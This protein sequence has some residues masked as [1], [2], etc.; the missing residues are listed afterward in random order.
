MFHVGDKVRFVVDIPRSEGAISTLHAI[1]L[2]WQSVSAGE[3]GVIRSVTRYDKS[4]KC[5]VYIEAREML[6]LHVKPSTLE[7]LENV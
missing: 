3:V 1:L 4:Q 2:P 5:D 6:I 7:K